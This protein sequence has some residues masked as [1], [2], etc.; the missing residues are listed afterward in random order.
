MQQE[1]RTNP[2]DHLIT[3]IEIAGHK[4]RYYDINKL[5]D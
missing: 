2:F 5:N 1:S 4:Y 3:E